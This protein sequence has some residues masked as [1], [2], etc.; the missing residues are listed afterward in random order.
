MPPLGALQRTDPLRSTFQGCEPW[1]FGAQKIDFWYTYENSFFLQKTYWPRL[2]ELQASVFTPTE[3]SIQTL[4]LTTKIKKSS[5]LS[6]TF[7]HH[8]SGAHLTLEST[9]TREERTDRKGLQVIHLPELGLGQVNIG[10]Q[11]T[12]GFDQWKFHL[13]QRLKEP[14]EK[15][16]KV[17]QW[18][19]EDL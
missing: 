9:T 16:K 2:R 1:A 17:A 8:P 4:N 12:F 11:A 15:K 13:E 6:L 7:T 19:A 18:K 14:K 5:W 10:V 3:P